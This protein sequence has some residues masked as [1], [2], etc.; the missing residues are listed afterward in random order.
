DYSR[1]FR[2]SGL[3]LNALPGATAE[4]AERLRARPGAVHAELVA[5]LDDW[6]VERLQRKGLDE[7][8]RQLVGLARTGDPGPGRG[9]LR[10]L[11]LEDAPPLRVT[12]GELLAEAVAA[13]RFRALLM[14]AGAA[15]GPR[16]A[17]LRRLVSEA[18]VEQLPP[19]SVLLLAEALKRGG[20]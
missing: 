11:L 19:A 9:R 12:S 7:R 17:R 4:L 14:A 3:D 15:H 6:V 10:Q 18:E 1:V 8:T 20:L 16:R 13:P 2:D 5:A